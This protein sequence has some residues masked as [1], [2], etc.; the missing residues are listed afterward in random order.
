M[1]PYV[2]IP[3]RLEVGGISAHG[4]IPT[5]SEGETESDFANIFHLRAGIN[6]LQGFNGWHDRS[7]DV[8]AG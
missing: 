1:I 4:S 6:P 2:T 5:G 3:A 8:G 7:W